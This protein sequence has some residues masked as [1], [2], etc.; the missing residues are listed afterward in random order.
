LGTVPFV[1]L[2]AAWGAEGVL[3]GHMAGGI[4]FGI[5]AILVVRSL[6]RRLEHST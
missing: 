2:G 3:V 6:I 5:G 4:L 1:T